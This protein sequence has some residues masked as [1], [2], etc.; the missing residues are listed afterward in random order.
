MIYSYAKQTYSQAS[1]L[2]T[3]H[4]QAEAHAHIFYEH[5][6]LVPHVSLGSYASGDT[7]VRYR[8]PLGTLL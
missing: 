7:F 4:I 1:E 6:V 2:K 5:L 3:W 8:R